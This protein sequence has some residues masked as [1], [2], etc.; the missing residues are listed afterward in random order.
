MEG[1][2]T[3]LR[4]CA[5]ELAIDEARLDCD[6]LL[7]EDLAID[8]MALVELL[9]VIEGEFGIALPSLEQGAPRTLGDVVALVLERIR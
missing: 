6:L 2:A 7:F 9:V 1:C 5:R 4:L 8:S 3:I